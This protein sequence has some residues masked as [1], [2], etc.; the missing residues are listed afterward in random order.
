MGLLDHITRPHLLALL[1]QVPGLTTRA[2]RDLLLR[3]LPAALTNTITRSDATATDLDQIVYVCD[4]WWPDPVADP[5]P[6]ADYPLR[7]LVQTAYDLAAGTQVA[8]A[9]QA[10]LAA[11]PATLDATAHPGCPYP[12]MVPFQA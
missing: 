11:L 12:G 3:D 6:V 4:R 1:A 7:V 5:A 10:V 8:G 9:L 2:G